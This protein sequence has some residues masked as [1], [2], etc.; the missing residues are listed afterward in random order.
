V[1]SLRHNHDSFAFA[2]F[3]M[4]SRWINK[5][6]FAHRYQWK[7]VTR[8]IAWHIS[9][10]HGSP[11]GGRSGMKM[12][13]A[14]PLS[15]LRETCVCHNG[16]RIYLTPARRASHPQC[17]PITSRTKAREWDAAVELIL[18]IASHILCN[19]VGAPIVRS[20]MDMSLSIEPTRPT[21]LR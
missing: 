8:C 16:I 19:A 17:L 11:S 7:I 5:N 6:W 12:K 4:L 18:S 10:S 9:S 21:I 2:H 1:S 15:K 14:P 3:T 20:V 13:S